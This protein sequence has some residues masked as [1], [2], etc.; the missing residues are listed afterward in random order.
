MCISLNYRYLSING[1]TSLSLTDLKKIRKTIEELGNSS[2]KNDI[3]KVYYISDFLQSRTQFIY[4]RESESNGRIF[5]TPNFPQHEK[6]S[7]QFV[8]D[9]VENVLNN[10]NGIC[11]SIANLSTLL[12]NNPVFDVETE[13]VI[14][15]EH[16][17]NKVLIDGKCYYFDNTWA[18]TR[19]E[20]GHPDGLITLKFSKKYLLFGNETALEIPAHR[21]ESEFIYKTPNYLQVSMVIMTIIKDL[22]IK[23]NQYIIHIENNKIKCFLFL[24]TFFDLL[25]NVLILIMIYPIP[26]NIFYH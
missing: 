11:M 12:L 21:K 1:N 3:E 25:F 20:Y 5:V 8:H 17:W 18:I 7:P 13:T 22:H 6:Y 26:T 4:G 19:S 14:G 23:K 16:V 24:N 10:N 2:I 15:A 9:T